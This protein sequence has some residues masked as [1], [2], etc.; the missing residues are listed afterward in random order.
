MALLAR[1]FYSWY[2]SIAYQSESQKKILILILGF[3]MLAYVINGIFLIA[4]YLV[5]LEEQPSIILST[6]VA[7]F[8]DFE[9][10]SLVSQIGAIAQTANSFGCSLCFDMD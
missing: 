9:P 2:K 5:W 1:A 3:S 10:E 4:S 8:P 7:F 6:D